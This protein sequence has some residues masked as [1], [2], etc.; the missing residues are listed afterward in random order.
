MKRRFAEREKLESQSAGVPE[1]SRLD[2][3]LRY[4]GNL[5]RDY[6]RSLHQLEQLQRVRKGQSVLADAKG[7]NPMKR[8]KVMEGIRKLTPL[9]LA[10]AELKTPKCVDNQAMT[11]DD[12]IKSRLIPQLNANKKKV[13]FYKGKVTDVYEMPDGRAQLK[14]LQVALWMHGAFP[15]DPMPAELKNIK[16]IIDD[17]RPAGVSAEEPMPLGST[18]T[19]PDPK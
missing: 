3:L 12:F 19:E 14:A 18:P 1:P 6:E 9:Q 16:F 7:A 13:I 2:R 8:K 5:Q 17:A 4:S 10:R 15:E 11:L